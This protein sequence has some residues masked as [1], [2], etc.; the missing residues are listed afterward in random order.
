MRYRSLIGTVALA[1][2][3]T[4]ASAAQAFDDAKFPDWKGLWFRSV[5]GAP[6]FDTSKPRGL[7]Q[8]APLKPEFQKLYEA[9]LADQAAGGQGNHTVFR[10]LPW[11]MPAMMNDPGITAPEPLGPPD[12][13]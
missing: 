3:L 11:G 1:A 5:L 13:G 2:G 7:T 8:Q 10:C 6:R 9:S 12:L 4:M